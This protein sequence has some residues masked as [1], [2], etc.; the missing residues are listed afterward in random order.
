MR[1][2][3]AAPPR[4]RSAPCVAV[5]GAGAAGYVWP[6]RP[7]LLLA[8]AACGA[9]STPAP[10]ADD[11]VPRGNYG[12]SPAVPLEQALAHLGVVAEVPDGFEARIVDA[13][14][15]R[16]DGF[17]L[18]IGLSRVEALNLPTV[19]AY[20][21]KGYLDAP[22]T[23]VHAKEEWDGGWVAVLGLPTDPSR[24]VQAVI[25]AGKDDL[26]CAAV[27][28]DEVRKDTVEIATRVCRSLRP[29]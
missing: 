14:S 9:A 29:R 25:R 8:L 3:L 21:T 19:E 18:T 23:Q 4:R 20:L 2:G 1:G 6:M 17:A 16:L 28:D 11:D 12:G 10:Q 5:D 22:G 7:W 15:V 27:E 26:M 13:Q 24:L